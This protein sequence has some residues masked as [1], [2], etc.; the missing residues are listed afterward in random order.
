MEEPLDMCALYQLI[1]ALKCKMSIAHVS[2]NR[3]AM[4][5]K[6]GQTS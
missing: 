5:L 3:V 4:L 2:Q 1:S 6:E